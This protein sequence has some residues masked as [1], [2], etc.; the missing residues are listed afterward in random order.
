M[1]TNGSCLGQCVD[2]LV[3]HGP[4]KGDVAGKL[5]ERIVGN[6]PVGRAKG[7]G[8]VFSVKPDPHEFLGFTT[9]RD[10]A[11]RSGQ[12]ARVMAE[13]IIDEISIHRG[14]AAPIKVEAGGSKLE[15]YAWPRSSR[16]TGCSMSPMTSMPP[17]LQ[18]KRS[19]AL[20]SV[21][22]AGHSGALVVSLR[23]VTS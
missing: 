3:R 15:V 18:A 13:L 21:I 7:A 11:P 20:A 1:S 17:L 19:M 10:D 14:R 9:Q 22:S 2:H 16:T 23:R 6:Q 4:A 5:S 8:D 12:M